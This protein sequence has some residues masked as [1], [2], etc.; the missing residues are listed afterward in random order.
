M[1]YLHREKN[2]VTALKETIDNLLPKVQL[3]WVTESLGSFLRNP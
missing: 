2:K 1:P 3:L